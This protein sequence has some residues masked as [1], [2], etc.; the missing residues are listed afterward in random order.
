MTWFWSHE[1]GF[2]LLI[3]GKGEGLVE[4]VQGDPTSFWTGKFER[5]RLQFGSLWDLLKT[6]ANLEPD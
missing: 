4:L 2:N 5:Y 3:C 6:S 1:T